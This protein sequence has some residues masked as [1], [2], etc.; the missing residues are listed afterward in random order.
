[1]TTV[2]SIGEV[3]RRFGLR[4]SA[5]RYYERHGLLTPPRDGTGQRYYR[6][7]D[8]RDVAFV[9]MCRDGGMQLHEIATMMGRGDS[10]VSWQQLV[11]DRLAAIEADLARLE[12]ARA[13]LQNALH[14]TADHPAVECPYA[15]RELAARVARILDS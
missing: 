2:M 4:D 13:Y 12:S 7:E 3:A 11:V 5:L 8:L 14:C 10:S 9:L 15:Q 1:M 6:D